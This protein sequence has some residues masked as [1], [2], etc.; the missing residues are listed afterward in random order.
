MTNI[1]TFGK[2]SRSS[3]NRRISSGDE[4]NPFESA[5]LYYGPKTDPSKTKPNPKNVAG[6]TRTLSAVMP[7]NFANNFLSFT[8]FTGN[9]DDDSF[10]EGNNNSKINLNNNSSKIG[11]ELGAPSQKSKKNKDSI[12]THSY[13]D[14]SNG[15]VTSSEDETDDL[16]EPHNDD[17]NEESDFDDDE[18]D[19]L[20]GDHGISP[21]NS[22]SSLAIS[23]ANIEANLEDNNNIPFPREL[24]SPPGSDPNS[25]SSLNVNISSKS[26]PLSVG[27]RLRRRASADGVSTKNFKRFFI[28]DIDATLKELLDREDTDQNCQITIEDTGPKFLKL[29]TANSNGFNQYDIR[30]TYR[31]SNLLQELT[32]AKRMGRK[33]MILDEA[34]LTENPVERLKRL[35]KTR[36]NSQ[37]F[38]FHLMKMI[39][40]NFSLQFQNLILNII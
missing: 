8:S 31:L 2:K 18:V 10:I 25:N 24:T 13:N 33:Q 19:P 16:N 38:M 12:I 37:E 7:K 6:R 30:G 14:Y 23:K 15:L 11:F 32:I 3:S 1:H 21:Y 35:I 9:N 4:L 34:R 20:A 17:D 36:Q 5:E 28:S 40:L 27:S 39:N 29:G 22:T 26:N